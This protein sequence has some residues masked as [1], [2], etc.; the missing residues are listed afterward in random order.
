MS[1]QIWLILNTC[2]AD[3]LTRKTDFQRC[4][5]VTLSTYMMGRKRRHLCSHGS[6]GCNSNQHQFL[7]L[8]RDRVMLKHAQVSQGQQ[9]TPTVPRLPWVGGNPK[10]P[11][12]VPGWVGFHH[13][14]GLGWR[15]RSGWRDIL[16]Y[17]AKAVNSLRLLFPW[18]LLWNDKAFCLSWLA[19]GGAG[20]A[21]TTHTL[22]GQSVPVLL[23]RV[24]TCRQMLPDLFLQCK[25]HEQN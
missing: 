19:C 9:P 3:S 23:R 16:F 1:W 17:C 15:A 20:F 5:L 8:D 21:Y 18:G 22:R 6:Y 25:A 4:A 13:P 2:A 24:A 7:W 14:V 12:R 10:M 11:R